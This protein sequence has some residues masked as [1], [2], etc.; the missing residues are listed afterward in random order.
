MITL[1][2]SGVDEQMNSHKQDAVVMKG[3]SETA[4]SEIMLKCLFQK[5]LY[6]NNPTS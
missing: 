4:F 5:A 2:H 1:L 3:V 6:T